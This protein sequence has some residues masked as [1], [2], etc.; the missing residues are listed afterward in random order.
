MNSNGKALDKVYQ[1]Y[2]P[3]VNIFIQKNKGTKEDAEDIFQ[4]AMMILVEKLKQDDFILTASLKTYVMAIS[5]NLWFK[6]LRDSK[7]NATSELT[8]IHSPVVMDEISLAIEQE[9]SYLDRLN[10]Y[11]SKVSSHCK[12]ILEMFYFEKKTI[13]EIQKHFGYTTKHNAQNQKYKCVEQVKSV[14]TKN[15]I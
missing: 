12:T 3:V 1:D 6:H 10:A 8:D 13:D 15:K 11:L 14:H 9:K 5:K 2:F 7:K 4:E